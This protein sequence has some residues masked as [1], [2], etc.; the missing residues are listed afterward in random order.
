MSGSPVEHTDVGAYALGL[1]EEEDRRA[2]EAHLRGC[3]RCRAE[4]RQMRGVADVLS[5]LRD[6][7]FA[8]A[9]DPAPEPAPAPE[10]SPCTAQRRRA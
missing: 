2:F 1:L 7:G 9:P 8:P 4:L 10:P 6:G 3:A 5:D